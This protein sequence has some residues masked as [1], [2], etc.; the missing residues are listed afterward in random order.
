MKNT[1][2]PG[3]II[4]VLS[5][6]GIVLSGYLTYL[7]YTKARATFCAADS[8]CDT[9]RESPYSAILGI[10]VAVFG[11]IGYLSIFISSFISV[12]YRAKWVL[13]YFFSLAGF[14]FSAYLTYIELFV[15]KAFCPYCVA[16]AFII[17]GILITLLLRKPDS[18]PGTSF[19]KFAILSGVIVAVVL[20]GS[21]FL[22]PNGLSTGSKDTWQVS[23]AKHLTEVGATMYGAYWCPH[24]MEQKE[25]FGEAFKYINYVECDPMGRRANPALCN[26][27]G[28]KGYPTWEIKGNFYPG[29]R[30]LEE[31]SNLSEYKEAK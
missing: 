25:L 6:L 9:V 7:Y 20:L 1:R 21:V 3:L 13:L 24:C 17:T 2:T 22:Q 15:I 28:I 10:P 11:V 31:L 14:V 12:S 4:L 18:L 29:V 27:K 16:S 19:T 5:A 30:S 23:L 8:G 26:E